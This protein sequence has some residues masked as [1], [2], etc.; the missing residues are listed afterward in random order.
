MIA[1]VK[2]RKCSQCR[3][4]L[5]YGE[6]PTFAD[7]CPGCQAKKAAG[8]RTGNEPPAPRWHMG[9]YRR[10]LTAEEFA[11]RLESERKRKA[12]VVVRPDAR[13]ER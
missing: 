3:K 2:G 10:R 1:D 7:W 8:L 9:G 13:N 5:G 12:A 4:G 11:E 6:K